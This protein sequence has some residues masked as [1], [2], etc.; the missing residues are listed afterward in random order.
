LVLEPS[1][2]F[3]QDE[4]DQLERW[5]RAGGTLV[6]AG[7]G[8]S[9]AVPLRH[10]GFELRALPGEVELAGPI[11]SPLVTGLSD[12][13]TVRASDE[14]SGLPAGAQAFLANQGR[15]FGALL[16]VG[17]G[18]V[19]IFSTPELFSNSSLRNQANGMLV[20]ALIG[21]SAPGT[22]A[23]DETHHGYGQST[24]K[25]FSQLLLDHSWGQAA[26]YAGLI[27]LVYLLLA[28]R[29]QGRPRPVVVTRGRSLSEYVG[30]LAALYHAGGKRSFAARHFERRLRHQ[31]AATLGLSA[32][33]D[34]RQL[35]DR[36]RAL[37]SNAGALIHGLRALS[38]AAPPSESELVRLVSD[39]EQAIAAL[40][41]RSTGS[42]RPSGES[43]GATS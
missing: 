2:W 40:R 42:A 13:V 36:S 18:R 29:R 31:A 38:D 1:S 27:T 24:Q 15:V 20:F 7:Q 41:P 16:T 32:D 11:G 37:G 6:A 12:Q 5:V 19:V 8:L 10:F 4:L 34:D 23:F 25:D 28:G 22:I 33:A 30:S 21:G 14:L 17:A 26:L 9:G 43:Q 39:T 3:A 35:E